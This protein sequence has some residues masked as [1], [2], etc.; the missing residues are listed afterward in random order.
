MF[1][2][3]SL[4]WC[5]IAYLLAGVCVGTFEA[6]LLSCLSPLGHET[7]SWA[8]IGIPVGFNGVSIGFYVLFAII[9]HN[10]FAHA[11][12]YF[13]IAGSC[14]AGAIFFYYYVPYIEFE[15]SHDGV[16]RF[17][18]NMV[19]WRD[20][21]YYIRTNCLALMIDMF[22]VSMFSSIVYYIYDKDELPIWTN[23]DVTI[24][25]NVFQTWYN[26]FAF[27]GDFTSRKLAYRG[28]LSR[29]VN[30]L[31]FLILSAVGAMCILSRLTLF[32]PFGM[33][34][35]MF[36]NG[37]IYAQTT[38]YIDNNVDARYN[39]IALSVWLF[40]GDIGSYSA[41]LVVQPLQIYIRSAFNST[42]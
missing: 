6:N 40:I 32:A 39:L 7:K 8:V 29:K 18:E 12:P 36:A 2:S 30:P 17:R 11:F 27:L 35:V 21:F 41:S 20:W 14:I 16:A 15:A 23:S 10:T 31:C 34:L 28:S 3:V 26:F 13:M 5:F 22:F 19:L 1:D 4:I 9:P 38:K 24:S 25:R 37:S 42:R 33:L